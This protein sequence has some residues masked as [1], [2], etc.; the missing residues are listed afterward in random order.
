[1]GDYTG[2]SNNATLPVD[3]PKTVSAQ[4]NTQY[5]VTFTIAGIPNSTV[6]KLNLNNATYNLST[7]NDYQAWYAKGSTINPAL[8]QTVVDGLMVYKFTGWR[9][10]TGGISQAPLAVNAPTNYAASYSTTMSLPPIPGFP[11]EAIILGILV[12]LL[13]LTVSR[14]R[15]HKTQLRQ[16]N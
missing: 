6:V 4:W 5:L 15:R 7:Q 16:S 3:S 11:I 10:S 1:V 2:A 8:N 14:K 13:L 9:N 12:G